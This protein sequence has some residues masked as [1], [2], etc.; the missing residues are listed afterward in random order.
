MSEKTD[1]GQN[2]NELEAKL[3]SKQR[4]YKI[5]TKLC[6]VFL[7]MLAAPFIPAFCGAEDSTW[8]YRLTGIAVVSIM[9][10]FAIALIAAN[11]EK[12]MKELIGQCAVWGVL[13][14][15]MQVLE[16]MPT[17]HTNEDFLKNCRLLPE[18]NEVTGSDYFHAIYRGAE[19][20]Y[21]DLCLRWRS[22]NMDPDRP[23]SSSA[24]TRFQGP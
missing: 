8:T 16:Y 15:Q 17:G 4:T 7:P 2:R 5:L 21:C 3:K 13:E 18:Y 24:V 9:I 14:E 10:G 23:G 11:I 12:Q 1:E 6:W 22:D 19:I 20:T